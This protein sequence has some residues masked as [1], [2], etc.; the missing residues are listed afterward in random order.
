MSR[1]FDPDA[2]TNRELLF[3]EPRTLVCESADAVRLMQDSGEFVPDSVDIPR[4]EL[5]R[6]IDALERAARQEV[7]A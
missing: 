4:S 6:V 3:E 1:V 5:R 7:L 2:E